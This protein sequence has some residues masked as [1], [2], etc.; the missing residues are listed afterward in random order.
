MIS[1]PHAGTYVPDHVLQRM[2]TEARELPDTDWHVDRLYN[3]AESMNLS[4]IQANYSRYVI[5]VNRPPDDASLYPGRTTTG[6]CPNR[7]FNGNPVYHHGREP[8]NE[9]ISS[10]INKIWAP[11]HDALQQGMRENLARFG[12]ALLYEAHSIRSTVPLLF[13]GRLPDLNLGTAD[14]NSASPDLQDRLFEICKAASDYTAVLNGRFKGGYITRQYGDPE[15]GVHAV[16]LELAQHC[17]MNEVY[18][19]N[20]I[21]GNASRIRIILR[22]LL[23]TMLRWKPS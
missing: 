13:D 5:D 15:K 20:Y 14:G 9:E 1:I 19:Y 3:F 8:D 7:L 10:R 2:T 12:Y 21:P 6:L 11:Y 18:P 16:Q 17:Y 4:I 23:D 22:Q